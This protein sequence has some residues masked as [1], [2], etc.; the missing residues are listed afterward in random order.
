VCGYRQH[1]PPPSSV[2]KT[3]RCHKPEGHNLY[4]L[5]VTNVDRNERKGKR[6]EERKK[7][8]RKIDKKANYIKWLIRI[9]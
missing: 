6:I 5:V 3:T 7:Y 2:Y 8:E 1:T 4:I 9:H